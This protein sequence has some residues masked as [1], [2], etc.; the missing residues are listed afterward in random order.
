VNL[1]GSMPPCAMVA[2]AEVQIHP[3]QKDS[4]RPRESGDL[5]AG[6]GRLTA[7]RCGKG[8]I[9]TGEMRFCG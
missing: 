9:E 8:E 6:C 7:W 3:P 4:L 5:I 2:M 1:M